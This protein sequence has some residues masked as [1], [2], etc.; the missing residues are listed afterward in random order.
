MSIINDMFRIPELRRRLLFTLFIMVI[1]RVGTQIPV[2][3]VHVNNLLAAVGNDTNSFVALINLLSGGA[4]SRASIFALGVTPYITSSI[5]MQLLTVIIPSLEK[6]SKDGPEGRRK[7]HQISRIGTLIIAAVQGVIY[8]SY[9]AQFNANVAR[10]F[11]LIGSTE[12]V[13]LFAISVTAGT[14]VL[15]W[16]GE[17]I[18]EK[19]IGNGVSMV[20]LSGIVAEFPRALY[21]LLNTP[22]DP[23]MSLLLVILFIGVVMAVLFEELALRRVPVQYTR[24]GTMQQGPTF[25][26]FKVNPTNVIPIIFASAVLVFP[27]QIAQWVGPRAPWLQTVANNMQP[28][29]F[30][31]SIT[32]FFLI[33]FFAFFYIEIELNPHDIAENLRRQNAYIP[34]VRPGIETEQ[35][36]ST[37]LYRLALPGAAFLG[38]IALLPTFIV[39]RMRVPQNIAYLMGGTSLIIMVGVS[40]N[41]LKQIEAFLNMHHKDGFLSPQRRNYYE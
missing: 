36:I 2:P 33:M 41:A 31:Y 3:G 17:R 5:V 16:L 22:Q 34:G 18:T 13:T 38:I 9:L 19:G 6:T 26:P 4:L 37:V 40:L 11:I 12:F 10:P 14:F 27:V 15:M 1:V 24:S 39:Y 21:T 23:I 30:W 20:I 25:L 29:T 28:G 32:Y 7:I 35:Y 8:G